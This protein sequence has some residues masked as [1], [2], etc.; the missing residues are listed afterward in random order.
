MAMEAASMVGIVAMSRS[1]AKYVCCGRLTGG[2]RRAC[3]LCYR[4]ACVISSWDAVRQSGTIP[5]GEYPAV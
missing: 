4:S 3:R 5:E 2:V 1:A